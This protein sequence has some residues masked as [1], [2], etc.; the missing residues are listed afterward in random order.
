MPTW[1]VTEE[2]AKGQLMIHSPG[3]WHKVDDLMQQYE[4]YA[5]AF[6]AFVDSPDCPKAVKIILKSVK[7]KYNQQQERSQKRQDK[8]NDHQFSNENA[9]ANIQSPPSTQPT[10]YSSQFSSQQSSQYLG[11]EDN[12]NS[13]GA[14]MLRDILNAFDNDALE[15]MSDDLPLPDGGNSFN[16]NQYAKDSF[17]KMC[18]FPTHSHDDMPS[19]C[20]TWLQ[21]TIGDLE[22]S[23]YTQCGTPPTLPNVN[24]LLTNEK[25]RIIVHYVIRYLLKLKKNELTDDELANPKRLLVQGP[26]GTGKSQTINIITRLVRRIFGND[27][28]TL[29]LAPTGAASVLL[30]DGKTIHSTLHPPSSSDSLEGHNLSRSNLKKLKHLLQD[31][32]GN[33]ILQNLN[34]DERGMVGQKLT[35]WMSRRCK[36]ISA[37]SKCTITGEHHFGNIPTFLYLG[38]LFQ[39]P[40]IRSL[41]LFSKPPPSK[42]AATRAGY[43]IYIGTFRDVI[44]LDEIMRQQPSQI[45]LLDRLNNIRTGQITQNDWR[46]INA[47]SKANLQMGPNNEWEKNFEHDKVLTLTEKWRLAGVVNNKKFYEMCTMDHP[48]A[49][50]PASKSRGYI[51]AQGVGIDSQLAQI[52]ARC[53]VCV[54]ARVM[55]TKNQQTLTRFGLNNGAMGTVVSIIYEEG[56]RPPNSPNAIVVNFPKYSGP[57]WLEG[58]PTWVPI[59]QIESACEN[60]CCIR[61]GFPLIP[62]YALTIPKCQGMTVGINE[63]CT[64]IVI[65]LTEETNMEKQNLGQ[66]YTAFSR[67]SEDTEWAIDEPI[68]WS[69]LECINEHKNMKARLYEEQR[70]KNL[71]KKTIEKNPCSRDD[72]LNLVSE[73]DE[74]CQDGIQD[75]I[76]N[77]VTGTC[78]CCY[79]SP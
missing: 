71:S 10:N 66:A 9:N 58:H 54:G 59:P 63:L 12:S 27:R 1:P 17:N 15:P 14:A 64:H 20:D 53:T 67:C 50:I 72:Y 69:R 38:D 57:V 30:P 36:E 73:I 35:A 34:T 62:S 48:C 4:T 19:D 51:H 78:R 8:K 42:D 3:T 40:A 23:Q 65:K 39:L 24:V 28:A 5:E 6:A 79:H 75:S 31:E 49:I 32:Q 21:T 29:N 25:Q 41:D 44:V 70:L 22:K 13:L 56:E 74:F 18:Q 2:Y 11:S 43:E 37:V 46:E 61:T 45:K 47:R 7:A 68:T 33:L 55:L 77:N 26:A 60:R 52:P 16:W 76:C